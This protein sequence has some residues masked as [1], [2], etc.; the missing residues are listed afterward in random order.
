MSYSEAGRKN[1]GR[2]QVANLRARFKPEKVYPK[3]EYAE[4]FTDEQR[5]DWA[6][7][8]IEFVATDTYR[9]HNDPNKCK[10]FN[11]YTEID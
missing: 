4:R 9:P 11:P 5:L 10:R 2:E 7:R 8:N 1:F 3:R 6:M